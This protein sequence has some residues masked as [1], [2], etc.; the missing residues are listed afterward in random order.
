MKCRWAVTATS[1]QNSLYELFSLFRFLR[2]YPYDENSSLS[3]DSD[4]PEQAL[5]R[6]KRLL[7]FVMLRRLNHILTLPKRTDIPIPLE[8]DGQDRAKYDLERHATIQ[9]LDD[10]LTSDTVKNGYRNAISQI[11]ALRMVCNLGCHVDL[12]EGIPSQ[13][14]AKTSDTRRFDRTSSNIDEPL[15]EDDPTGGLP[16][17]CILCGQSPSASTVP[18]CEDGQTRSTHK[19]KLDRFGSKGLIQCRSRSYFS[20]VIGTIEFSHART[21]KSHLGSQ[22]LGNNVLRNSI[23]SGME[24]STKVNALVRDLQVQRQARKRSVVMLLSQFMS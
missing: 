6:L 16:S 2:L 12:R 11:N 15:D 3:W 10:I 21:P 9:Y 22:P 8:L 19:S 5:E 4:S 17:T 18:F 1:I 20:D 23:A 24:F 13:L 7:G 14:L